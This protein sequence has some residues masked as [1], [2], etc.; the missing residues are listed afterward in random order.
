[1]VLNSN[2]EHAPD[3]VSTQRLAL[4]SVYIL[5]VI[6]NTVTASWVG[7][8]GEIGMVAGCVDPEQVPKDRVWTNQFLFKLPVGTSTPQEP[9]RLACVGEEWVPRSGGWALSPAQCRNLSFWPRLGQPF[10]M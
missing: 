1:M 9:W 6:I 8:A 3:M 4:V 7:G 5:T 10:C 2:W